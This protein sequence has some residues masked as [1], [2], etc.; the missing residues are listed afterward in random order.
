MIFYMEAMFENAKSR[1]NNFISDNYDLRDDR[2]S[3]K[4]EHTYNVVKMAEYI[5]DDLKLN[6][7]DRELA[8]LIALLHDIGRFEQAKEFGCFREDISN[9]DHAALGVKLLFEN[10]FIR[11][12]IADTRFDTIIKQAIVNHSRYMLSEANLTEREL[13]HCKLIRDAD[14]TDSF[15]VKTVSDIYSTAN[16]T[17]DE[18]ENS[19]ISDNVLNDFMSAKTIL[20]SDR[21]T[22]ADIW[23]SYIAFVFDF[24]FTSGLKYILENDY[25]NI[26]ARRFDFK[27]PDT[28]E[29]MERIRRFALDHIKQRIKE[30]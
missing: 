8:K 15:R 11:E 18:L 22:A 7:E 5:A 20:S 28:K 24:N 2:I 21:K 3:G 9:Y 12:F 25:I 13:L 4:L 19:F 6:P 29:K 27:I 16:V 10:G 17:Q 23:V 26:L 14:K 30:S 1:F